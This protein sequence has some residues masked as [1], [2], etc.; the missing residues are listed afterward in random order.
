MLEAFKYG[1]DMARFVS[2]K[3]CFSLVSTIRKT[4]ARKEDSV[5]E[6]VDAMPEN[7]DIRDGENGRNLR[8]V[9]DG[10]VTSLECGVEGRRGG[11]EVV[12]LTSV[13]G[14]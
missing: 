9:P 2:W 10:D 3:E 8:R 14:S 12:M 13:L 5:L 7:S 11:T 6:D 1:I 4:R